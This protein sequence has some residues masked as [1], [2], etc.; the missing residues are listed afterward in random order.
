MHS[1]ISTL[2]SRYKCVTQ[3]DYKNALKEIIQE[4]ALLGLW[5]SKFF[6]KAAFY[7]GTALRILYGLDRFSE[8]LDFSLLVPDSGFT[9]APYERAIQ[10]ELESFGFQVSF[11]LVEKN[12]ETAIQSAFLKANTLEH[13]MRI[14]VP[15][16]ERKRCHF[17]E[18]LKIKLECDTDPPPAFSTE[19]SFLLQPI[20]F[21]I[22][23]FAKADLFAGKMHAL[24]FRNWQQRVKGRDWYDFVWFVGK[25]IPL[26]LSHLEAR[27]KQTRHLL[28]EET[29]TS[30]HFH[31]LLSH[32]I[33][34]LDLEQAKKDILPFVRNRDAIAVWSPAFFHSVAEKIRVS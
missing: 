29:L 15:A 12:Q 19:A 2:L 17:E 33:K 10:T 32:K 5:R 23:T 31:A 27:M 13:F 26:H 21:S 4:V 16:S 30:S 3:Q 9:L 1:M 7:G 18:T 22:V 24:L 20:P 28:P 11:H 8:D 6:E 14:G 34:N 25:G